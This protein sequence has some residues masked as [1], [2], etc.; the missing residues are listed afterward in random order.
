MKRVTLWHELIH[1]ILE[2]A[3]IHNHDEQQIDAIA[4]GIVAVLQAVPALGGGEA[5]RC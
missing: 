3:G 5:R 4:Y 2:N 1:G